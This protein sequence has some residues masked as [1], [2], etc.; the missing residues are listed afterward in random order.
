VSF[1]ALAGRITPL[2]TWT[3]NWLPAPELKNN[4]EMLYLVAVHKL[5]HVVLPAH[6]VL[7]ICLVV[8]F[9][10]AIYVFRFRKRL[11]VASLVALLKFLDW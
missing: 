1:L 5:P 11:F 3:T 10:G 4:I 8:A 2:G 6:I 9:V 7:S